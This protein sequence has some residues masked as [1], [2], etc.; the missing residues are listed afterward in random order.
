MADI[1]KK[2]SLSPVSRLPS[3]D[4]GLPS[5]DSP[6]SRL[7]QNSAKTMNISQRKLFKQKY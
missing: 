3:P 5:P 1:L 6:V 7:N 4:F 2:V